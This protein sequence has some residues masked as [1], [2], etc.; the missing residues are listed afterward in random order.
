MAYV[1]FHS[2]ELTYFLS[3]NSPLLLFYN[4]FL[5]GEIISPLRMREGYG[6]L[7]V[8]ELPRYELHSLPKCNVPMNINNILTCKFF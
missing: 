2:R 3:V 5:F 4:T 7:C 8:C 6:R 1:V